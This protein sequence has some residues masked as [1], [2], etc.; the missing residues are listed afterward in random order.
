MNILLIDKRVQ[1]YETIVAAIDPALA[2]GIVFDYYEDTFDAVKARIGALGL[3]N[4]TN[5]ISVGLIQHNYNAPMFTM[6][7]S[8]DVSPVEQVATQ[9]PGLERWTQFREFIA[10]CKSEFN[11]A[12]FDT[13]ACAIYSDPDWKYVIDTLTAQTGVE[14]RASTDNTG[15]PS[16][17]GNW[18]L[19]SHTGVNL[20]T[21]YFTD[22]IDE[23][24]GVLYIEPYNFQKYNTKGI[25][26]GNIVTWGSSTS[27]GDSSSVDVS[28]NIVS[29]YS[30]R[31]AFAALNTSGK[32]VTWGNASEGG[33]SSSVASS[34]A[35]GVV[36]ISSTEGSFAALKSNGSVVAWGTSFSGGDS[37]SV[38]SS[39]ASGVVKIYTTQYAYAALKSN[40]SLVTWGYSDEGG[41]SSSVASSLA[42]GVVS[43]YYT[44]GAFAALKSNG[45]VVTWGGSASGG[46][47]SS[48]NVSSQV[49]QM[50]STIKAFAALKS[51]GSVVTWGNSNMGGNSSS[52]SSSLASGVVAVYCSEQAFAA[53]KIN[54]SVVTWGASGTGGDSS[55]VSSS[56]ESGIVSIFS[57]KSAF[58]ALKSNGSVVTWGYSASGG[59]SSSVSSSL[60]SDVV[61]LYSTDEAF[62]ALKSN[63]S[64]V[65]WGNSSRGGNSSSV[66]S[67]LASGVIGIYSNGS[68]FAALKNDGSVVTWGDSTN[69]AGNSSS[70]SLSSGVISI[71]PSGTAFAAL[72]TTASIF[73]LSMSYYTD[74]DRYDI[75]RKKE[76]R[77]RVNLTTL[78][79]NVF[80][81]SQSFDVKL[82]NREIPSNTTLSLS[83]IVPDY[84]GTFP[85]SRTSTATLPTDNGNFIVACD[86]GEPVTISG[87]SYVNFGSFVYKL[88]TNNTYTKLVT[89]TIGAQSYTLY[90]G[91]GINSSGIVFVRIKPSAVLSNFVVDTPKT[92]GDVPFSITAPTSDSSGAIT[93]SSNA[94]GVAT[95]NPSS[96]IITL[97]AAGTVT[98]TASQAETSQY[99][100]PTPVTSNP[101][102]VA[103]GTTTLAFVSPPTTKNLIDDAFTVVASSAS[104]GAVTYT[105]SNTASATVGLTTG[106]VTLI[107][108]GSVTITA[109]QA[110]S[111]QYNAPTN[112]TFTMTIGAPTNLAGTVVTTSLASK[113]LTGI[114]LVG[115][116][117]ANISLTNTILRNADLSGAVVT[118][119]SFINTDI[120]GATN[121]PVFSTKQK[122]QLMRNSNNAAISAVQISTPLSGAEINAAIT[123]P[124]PDISAATFVV[125]APSY[126]VN[127]EKV[128]TVTAQDV[129]N[130]VSIYI[131]MNSNETVKVNGVAYTF[132]GTNI[133]N[134]NGSVIHF[135]N[136][137]GNPFRL[138][139]GSIVGLNVSDQLNNIK[140]NGDGLY[141]IL[142]GLFAAKS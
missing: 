62:A 61:A 13:M 103:L 75:L 121:L 10:W 6:L 72:K 140:L 47:S 66:S 142:T 45:S 113:N 89:T 35:S 107:D 24:Q 74:I 56:L 68:V 87:T 22:A 67:S 85:L 132:D 51:D 112:T 53:L 41:N 116:N 64:V 97:V 77:R 81:L 94:S 18:F 131:P 8:A 129:S 2:V 125:K 32:L 96:G 31:S 25:V 15:P 105:S 98:F 69:N 117:L 34:L 7:A 136:V 90:G 44:S 88:E 36:N 119:A 118:G 78:N 49:I 73:D 11:A 21:V 4:G 128:V 80:T 134:S 63:G 109:A 70:A 82:I 86:E 130:N 79:N 60:S 33:N 40:G 83:I 5:Q 1:D 12:H 50:Y 99:N 84:Y 14:F 114:S 92:F 141:D 48:V 102:T 115:T 37:S 38:A 120:S 91:D 104:S 23:Y 59:N 133:L 43:V 26:S 108:I 93:Y 126:N 122:L 27:G 46:N 138:Y 20:K 9:D 52:V 106:L 71:Y 135:I 101:L 57:S 100:A 29:V 95:I 111:A 30:T 127:N 16:L 28:S 76:N 65:T 19:E 17:G 137:L 58:A 55:S 139:A 124:I 110:A 3:T 123:T 39:L 42:S 54:G